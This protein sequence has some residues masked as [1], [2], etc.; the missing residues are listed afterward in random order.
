MKYLPNNIYIK[1]IILLSH[2]CHVV[3]YTI[4]THVLKIQNQKQH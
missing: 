3:L 4:V 2:V 1:I